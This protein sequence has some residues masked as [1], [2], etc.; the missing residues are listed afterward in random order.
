MVRH[1]L[2]SMVPTELIR[3]IK[4]YGGGARGVLALP[5]LGKTLCVSP[6]QVATLWQLVPRAAPYSPTVPN[7]FHQVKT[8]LRLS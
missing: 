6:K 7:Y 3:Q 8:L 4:K 5:T 1:L 2:C